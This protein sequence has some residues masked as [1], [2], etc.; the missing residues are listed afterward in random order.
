MKTF[1]H[2]RLLKN[3]VITAMNKIFPGIHAS[4]TSESKDDDEDDVQY[5]DDV[6]ISSH[7]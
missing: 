6:R 1:R 7:F 4:H 2:L 3:S 5:T